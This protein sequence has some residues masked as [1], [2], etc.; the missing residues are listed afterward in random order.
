MKAWYS[1][2]HWVQRAQSIYCHRCSITF[3]CAVSQYKRIT[4]DFWW[5]NRPF[6]SR[7]VTIPVDWARSGYLLL[8]QTF[9]IILDGPQWFSSAVVNTVGSQQILVFGFLPQPKIMQIRSTGY[10]K[11]PIGANSCLLDGQPAHSVSCLVPKVSW[12]YLQ[13]HNPN[14]WYK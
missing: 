4:V 3:L 11:L 13:L 2:I 9:R 7:A 12:D 14:R 5:C 10:L 1:F 6:L 8:T